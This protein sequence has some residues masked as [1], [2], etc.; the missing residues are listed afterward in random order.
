MDYDSEAPEGLFCDAAVASSAFKSWVATESETV[1]N[2]DPSTS[3]AY[4]WRVR[5]IPRPPEGKRG[6]VLILM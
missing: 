4:P 3:L 5:A 1:A 2:D 6:F